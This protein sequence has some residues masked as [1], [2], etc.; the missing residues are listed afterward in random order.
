MTDYKQYCDTCRKNIISRPER[1]PFCN[2]KDCLIGHGYYKRKGVCDGT[3]SNYSEFYIKRYRCKRFNR[4]V[5]IHPVFSHVYKRYSLQFVIECL[6]ML[7]K[8]IR[9]VYSVSKKTGI[10]RQTLKRW[11]KTFG[12]RCLEA[13]RIFVFKN[14]GHH[15]TQDV[16]PMLLHE[17]QDAMVSLYDS[18]NALLY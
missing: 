9:S 5:S 7:I 10:A 12:N 13:K 3:G 6:T 11:M 8:E 15:K 14:L 4:T 17:P 1:C 18:Y 16:L 2:R